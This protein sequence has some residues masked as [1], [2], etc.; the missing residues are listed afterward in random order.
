MQ[1]GQKNLEPRQNWKLNSF[2]FVR[3]G[4]LL[5]K[6]SGQDL[7][8]GGQF[9]KKTRQYDEATGE[10]LLC[11]SRK[12]RLTIVTPSEP[13]LTNF[14]DWWQLDWNSTLRLP[15]FPRTS[16]WYKADFGLSDYDVKQLTATEEYL[17]F[18]WSCGNSRRET[19]NLCQTSS[20]VRLL[21]TQMLKVK[22]LKKS[23]WHQSTWLKCWVWWQTVQFL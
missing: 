6:T 8:S 10:T 3:K 2:N 19:Q 18:L 22:R 21:N 12:A 7:R 13:D 17:R 15:A 23:V 14:W 1:N 20:K 11:G 9:V 4:W 5:R 16:R